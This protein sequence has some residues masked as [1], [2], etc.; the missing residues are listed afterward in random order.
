MKQASFIGI[1]A[2]AVPAG[3]KVVPLADANVVMLLSAAS[4]LVGA[5]VQADNLPLA[6][7]IASTYLRM[8]TDEGVCPISALSRISS[9]Q[10]SFEGLCL[11]DTISIEIDKQIHNVP[12]NLIR[13]IKVCRRRW[14]ERAVSANVELVDGSEYRLAR[15]HGRR[16]EFL[17]LIGRQ[18]V[19]LASHDVIVRGHTVIAL[20]EL[21]S[22]LESALERHR[23]AMV[24]TVGQETLERFF[25]Q[26]A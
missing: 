10:R 12:T 21:R 24:Q 20:D 13:R 7:G 6:V 25:V 16:L 3:S 14:W 2:W 15:L 8:R 18:T 22:R 26:A 17:T 23:E 19:K 9:R 4:G 5:L 1:G 11:T